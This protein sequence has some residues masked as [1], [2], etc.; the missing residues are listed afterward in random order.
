V[1]VHISNLTGVTAA[2]WASFNRSSAPHNPPD[3]QEQVG[4]GGELFSAKFLCALRV[5]P[6]KSNKPQHCGLLVCSSACMVSDL[7]WGESRPVQQLRAWMGPRGGY[8]LLCSHP[9]GCRV[10]CQR[11]SP[12]QTS[13]VLVES[14]LMVSSPFMCLRMVPGMSCSSAFAGPTVKPFAPW[15]LRGARG[16]VCS[17][18]DRLPVTPLRDDEGLAVRVPAPSIHGCISSGPSA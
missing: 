5:M 6:F 16:D 12:S 10:H 7:G 8:P 14:V 15:A 3:S 18:Q 9:S 1:I 17:F 13:P 2:N 11:G 4:A